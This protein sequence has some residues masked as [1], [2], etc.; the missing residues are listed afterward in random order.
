MDVRPL[1]GLPLAPLLRLRSVRDAPGKS[2]RKADEEP[3]PAVPGDVAREVRVDDCHGEQPRRQRHLRLLAA[4]AGPPRA[5]EIGEA[6]G[7]DGDDEHEPYEAE[8]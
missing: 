1:D 2:G 5:H 8:L 7:Q 6:G 3:E 4:V